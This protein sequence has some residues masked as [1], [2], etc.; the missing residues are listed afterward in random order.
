MASKDED[1]DK[2]SDEGA[3]SD[4]HS[5]NLAALADVHGMDVNIYDLQGNMINTSQ[6]AFLIRG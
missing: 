4:T 2:E 6:P 5:I 3:G 1:Q